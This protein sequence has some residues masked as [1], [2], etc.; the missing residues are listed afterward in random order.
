MNIHF[1]VVLVVFVVFVVVVVV[2]VVVAVVFVVFVA[3]FFFVRIPFRNIRLFFSL[4]LLLRG[5]I[6]N[7]T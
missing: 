3:M 5:A 4:S 1:I 7:R 6:V 2:V